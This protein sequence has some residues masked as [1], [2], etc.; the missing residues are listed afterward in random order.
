MGIEDIL[1][2]YTKGDQTADMAPVCCH[3]KMPLLPGIKR[4]HN[5]FR[6]LKT[7]VTQ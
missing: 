2:M 5:P 3:F 1:Y 4:F 6:C 7:I